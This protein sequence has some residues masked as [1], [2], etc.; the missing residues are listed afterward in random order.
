LG[1]QGDPDEIA[2]LFGAQLAERPQGARR[3]FPAVQDRNSPDRAAHHL[4]PADGSR[5]QITD[6]I[7]AVRRGG[8]GRA[9]A[10]EVRSQLLAGRAPGKTFANDRKQRKNKPTN[11]TATPISIGPNGMIFAPPRIASGGISDGV[12]RM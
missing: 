3:S 5:G 7:L 9:A 11:P 4:P 1:V 8:A 12:T 6:G 2:P 10:S